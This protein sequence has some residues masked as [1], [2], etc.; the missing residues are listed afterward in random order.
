[1][2]RDIFS[3]PEANGCWYGEVTVP[4]IF[5][6]R[7]HEI[8]FLAKPGRGLEEAYRFC[9]SG[10]TAECV[11]CFIATDTSERLYEC[12]GVSSLFL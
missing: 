1:M 10:F 9:A 6:Q 12:Y 2:L 4:R 5:A 8:V 11:A 3:T 7:W